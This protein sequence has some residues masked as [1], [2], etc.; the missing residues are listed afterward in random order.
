MTATCQAAKK[1]MSLVYN[2]TSA[3]GSEVPSSVRFRLATASKPIH[4]MNSDACPISKLFGHSLQCTCLSWD[5][6]YLPL[7]DMMENGPHLSD[8]PSTWPLIYEVSRCNIPEAINWLCSYTLMTASPN[9]KAANGVS[10]NVRTCFVYDCI[11]QILQ[12]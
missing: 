3:W 12:T 7:H 1:Y 8:I 2:S 6:H 9:S 5:E 10:E 4:P 11:C